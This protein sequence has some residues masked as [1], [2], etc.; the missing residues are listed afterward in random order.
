VECSLSP[1][2]QKDIVKNVVKC[3]LLL[4]VQSSKSRELAKEIAY[5]Y[6]QYFYLL[7]NHQSG[8]LE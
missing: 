2:L 3:P 7:K 8:F 5:I 6:F 4:D 1:L